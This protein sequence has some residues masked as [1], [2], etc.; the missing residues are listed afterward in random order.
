[1]RPVDDRHEGHREPR[2]ND[3]WQSEPCASWHDENEQPEGGT[4]NPDGEIDRAG[5]EVP[6]RRPDEH[7]RRRVRP[8]RVADEAVVGDRQRQKRGKRDRSGEHRQA[9]W[10]PTVE[11]I[12]PHEKR[13]QQQRREVEEVPLLDPVVRELGVERGDDDRERDGKRDARRD[14]CLHGARLAASLRD[15]GDRRRDRN[16]SKVQIE[17]RSTPERE[18]GDAPHAVV[19]AA[20]DRV[21]A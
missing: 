2:R 13:D 9:P 4:D 17:I 7:E 20:N 19:P 21:G 14:E 1:M 12:G 18:V 8:N 11:A 5:N 3:E 16:H 6:V 15:E 10:R